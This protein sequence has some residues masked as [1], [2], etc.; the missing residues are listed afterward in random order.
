VDVASSFAQDAPASTNEPSVSLKDG[1]YTDVVGDAPDPEQAMP[2]AAAGIPLDN[3]E[4]YRIVRE[5]AVADSGS[6]LYAAIS[7]DREYETQ[8]HSAYQRRHF[9]LGFGLVLFTQESGQLGAVLQLMQ[10]RE[11]QTF[12]EIFGSDAQTL[13]AVTNAP[14]AQERLQPVGGAP[15][16][17]AAWLERFRRAGAIPAFQAAQNEQAIEGQFRPMLHVA[18]NL[19]LDTDRGLAMVYDRVVTRGLG[20]GI[21]W[22][23]QAVGPF[24]T[25]AQRDQALRALGA[26][27]L[28][29]LQAQAGLVPDGNFGPEKHAALVGA[30]RDQ[31]LVPLP[32]A[33]DLISQMVEGASGAAKTRLQRLQA[34]SVL[35]DVVYVV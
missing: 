34:S 3:L 8:G 1:D 19:G 32:G 31:G 24:R 29:E 2:P 18:L 13:L 14:T 4:I 5:V 6:D 11:P 25:K 21:R 26:A 9:G 30:L 17:S 23:V 35:H 22:V 15:L 7:A 12:A 33:S 27:D 28:R 16:W 20:G 10:T